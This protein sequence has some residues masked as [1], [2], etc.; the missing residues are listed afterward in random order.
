MKN[1]SLLALFWLICFMVE[2]SFS[3]DVGS[4]NLRPYTS[5]F[6]LGYACFVLPALSGFF[7][8]ALVFIITSSFSMT[9]YFPF[10]SIFTLYFLIFWI[11]RKTFVDNFLGKALLVFAVILGNSYLTK[12][13]Y[14]VS[15]STGTFTFLNTVY[16]FAYLLMNILLGIFSFWTLE[17][18]GKS[19]EEKLLSFRWKSQ[20]SPM[21]NR[22][23]KR[24][25]SYR[26]KF[27][28]SPRRRLVLKDS[29]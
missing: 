10:L 21:R 29:W 26:F 13:F 7:L 3:W 22:S 23:A 5:C 4:V 18:K 12:V 8:A 2:I 9:G 6:I 1:F 15:F 14:G 28:R 20:Q 11:K 17:V 24:N 16:Y 27:A 25:K 19:W